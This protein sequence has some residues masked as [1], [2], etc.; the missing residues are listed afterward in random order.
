MSVFNFYP[1]AEVGNQ[2]SILKSTPGVE[3]SKLYQ[4]QRANF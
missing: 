3:N 1:L 4:K 2:Q